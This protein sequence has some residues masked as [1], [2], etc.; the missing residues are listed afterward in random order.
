MTSPTGSARSRPRRSV[1][2]G[3]SD[4]LVPVENG[5]R[6]AADIPGAQLI[7]YRGDR[8]HPRGRVLRALQRRPDRV[9]VVTVAWDHRHRRGASPV[10]SPPVSAIARPRAEW[11]CRRWPRSACATAFAERS[12]SRRPWA[13]ARSSSA[14][15]P[16]P[17]SRS[18]STPASMDV[19][20]RLALHPRPGHRAGH[21]RSR[22]DALRDR[23]RNL[24]ERAPG[25][26]RG[27][28]GSGAI[29]CATTTSPA[30]RSRSTLTRI[31]VLARRSTPPARPMSSA[32][33]CA[34]ASRCA[35]SAPG[36]GTAPRID[37]TRA[38]RRCAR[39][40][41]RCSATPGPT[42]TRW[43]SRSTVGVRRSRRAGAAAARSPL[44]EGGRRAG[45]TGHS[46]R[47]ELVGLESRGST[48][49]GSRSRRRRAR[50]S[51]HTEVGYRA[52]ANKTLLL[53]LNGALAKRGVATGAGGRAM[54]VAGSGRHGERHRR[55][56]RDD[57]ILPAVRTAALDRV[58]H[59]RAGGDR[60]VGHA[61]THRR[62]LGVDDQAQPHRRSSSAPDTARARSSSGAR[63]RAERWDPSS[64]GVLGA[65]AFAAP[66]ARR[67]RCCTWSKFNDGDAPFLAAFAFWGWTIVYIISPFGR[68]RPV[69]AQSG[70]LI[71]DSRCPAIR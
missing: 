12:G 71:P 45:L 32:R 38:A 3:D 14:S 7:V 44:P 66:H 70:P 13:S 19:R 34:T 59:P 39:P 2:D 51:P 21:R 4:P 35:Q 63:Y 9:P 31:H 53:L 8:P 15:P 37:V 27:R 6:L 62:S 40:P 11:W 55:P 17:A 36:R 1:I 22:P 64:A 57:R 50:Y 25:R 65:S 42:G 67:P 56:A 29:G 60:P 52:P 26:R 33:H 41:T 5:R 54:T 43:S 49:V 23:V 48:R 20:K 16:T 58:P 47:A 24:A 18:P 46:Y 30:C 61:R 28:A 68:V 69:V 10:T